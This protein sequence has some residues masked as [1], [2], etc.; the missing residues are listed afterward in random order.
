MLASLLPGLR[1]V[2]TPLTVGYLWLLVAWSI[3]GDRFP[4]RSADGP[5]ARLYRLS[6]LLG[7]TA[8]LASISFAAYLVGAIMT[9]PLEG[10]FGETLQRARQRIRFAVARWTDKSRDRVAVWLKHPRKSEIPTP[11]TAHNRE[12]KRF[13]RAIIANH[14]PKSL[15]EPEALPTYGSPEFFSALD[16]T[17]EALRPRLLASEQGHEIYGEY[18]RAAAEASF[19]IN[20]VLPLIALG[21][22]GGYY[23]SWWVVPVV[24]VVGC[25]L[26]IQGLNRL[27]AST[28]TIQRAAMIGLFDHP[29]DAY[30]KTGQW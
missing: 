25:V 10:V 2:R 27:H 13:L 11:E 15:T 18:D 20:V 17:P 6:D 21:F 14:D 30:Y 1:D 24:F 4:E 26:T 5:I 23:F 28:E 12:Y 8:A 16:A 29:L 7:N 22:L 19:R 3:W 9:V